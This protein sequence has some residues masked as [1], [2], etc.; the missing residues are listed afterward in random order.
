MTNNK[1]DIKLR[2]TEVA[3]LNNAATLDE[4]VKDFPLIHFLKLGE[5]E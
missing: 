4:A 2:R 5:D 1:L 3:D